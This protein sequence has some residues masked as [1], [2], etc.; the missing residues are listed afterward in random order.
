[1]FIIIGRDL[2]APPIL[3][4]DAILCAVPMQTPPIFALRVK[5]WALCPPP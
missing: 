2:P 5:P 3:R 4:Y 1:V